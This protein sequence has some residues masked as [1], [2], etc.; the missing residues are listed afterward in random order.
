[1]RSTIYLRQTNSRFLGSYQQVEDAFLGTL[2]SPGWLCPRHV[3][4]SAPES[5]S[6]F[7]KGASLCERS[8]YFRTRHYAIEY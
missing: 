1:M 6:S 2:F 8:S 5:G 7:A 3:E 4:R